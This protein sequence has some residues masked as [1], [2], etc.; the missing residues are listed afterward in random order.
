MV[1]KL[2]EF[3]IISRSRENRYRDSLAAS[4]FCMPT[5]AVAQLL[6]RKIWGGQVS[7]AAAL[8]RKNVGAKRDGAWGAATCRCSPTFTPMRHG[9][10]SPGLGSKELPQILP[11]SCE[12]VG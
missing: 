8:D 6:V 12:V 3:G 2:T 9:V 1:N 4:D 10:S 7:A 11:A 5:T